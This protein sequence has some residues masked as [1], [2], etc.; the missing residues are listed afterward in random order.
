[1]SSTRRGDDPVS[2]RDA[3]AAVGRE[4]GMPEPGAFATLAAAWPAVVGEG[5]AA[6][7]TLRSVRD[8][9]CTVEVDGAGWAT[10]LRYA[11]RQ[12][13]ERATVHCG[14]GVVTSIRALSTRGGVAS[15][16]AQNGV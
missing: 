12:I 9:V 16:E 8:G 3:V 13:V 15:G 6:H 14:P 7:V 4:L 11:E 1:M 5:L 10:Q 2:L